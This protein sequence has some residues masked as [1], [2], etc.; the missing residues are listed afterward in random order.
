M[1]KSCAGPF[2]MKKK[3]TKWHMH[4]AHSDQPG[5]LPSLISFHCL[6]VETLAPKQPIE[7]TAK[8]DQ[9]GRI[10]T[11][12]WFFPGSP[13]IL[14]VLSCTGSDMVKTVQISRPNIFE[15]TGTVA[16]LLERPAC[17]REVVGSVPGRVMPKTFKMVLA[18]LSFALSIEKVE[19]VGPVSV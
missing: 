7:C 9:T 18:A 8:T 17:V 4:P 13:V 6:H 11:L 3:S 14:L 2:H 16:K 10:P 19:L 12:I 1:L 15:P 5:H